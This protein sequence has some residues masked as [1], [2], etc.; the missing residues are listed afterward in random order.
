MSQFPISAPTLESVLEGRRVLFVNAIRSDVPSGGNTST[1]GML[2]RWRTR[3]SLQELSLNP[4]ISGGTPLGFALATLPAALFVMWARRSGHV[5]LEFLFRASPW[6]FLRCLWARWRTRPEVVVFNHHSSFLYLSAFAGCQRVLV[7]HDV[8]S[9]KRDGRREI[10]T[11][12]RR[13][14][15][16]ERMALSRAQFNVTFSFDDENALR[17]LHGRHSTVIPVIDHAARPREAASRPRRWLL[18]G[19]WTRAEN[20]EGTQ[21]FLIACAKLSAYTQDEAKAEAVFHVAGHDSEPFIARLRAR[22]PELQ[23]LQLVTTA[24]YDDIRGFEETALLAPLLRGAGIKL[25]TIEAWSVGIP[26][27]GTA[28]AFSGLPAKIWHLGGLRMS[29]IEEMARLCL[30]PGA[31]ESAAFSLDA[32]SAYEAYQTKIHHSAGAPPR[33]KKDDTA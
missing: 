28:Q 19:N 20:C 15:G 26:V 31:Y 17:R 23:T 29:S 2:A 11:G 25:K 13:C 16:L 24:R 18:I 21:A 9:L 6:L 3:C 30:T 22:H 14:A 27:V 1:Q 7:W 33:T 10:A 32:L 4:R 12:V 8:P 5:W